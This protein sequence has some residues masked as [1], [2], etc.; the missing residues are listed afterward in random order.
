MAEHQLNLTEAKKAEY[1][2]NCHSLAIHHAITTTP[3]MTTGVRVLSSPRRSTTL[4]T[5]LDA[6][7][8]RSVE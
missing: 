4:Y 1:K 5:T 6:L 3:S 2:G 8:S 7:Q